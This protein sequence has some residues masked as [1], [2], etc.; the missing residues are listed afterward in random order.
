MALTWSGWWN[1]TDGYFCGLKSAL[2]CKAD[3]RVC[4]RDPP[5]EW[6]VDPRAGAIRTNVNIISMTHPISRNRA[7]DCDAR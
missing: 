4:H 6:S 3:S 7:T 1:A 2:A 5:P